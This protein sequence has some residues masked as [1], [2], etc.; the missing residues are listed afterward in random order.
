MA[1]LNYFATQS[2]RSHDPLF[3]D[4][5]SKV[6]TITSPHKA[7][8]HIRLYTFAVKTWGRSNYS[9]VKTHKDKQKLL[10]FF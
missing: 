7:H 4:P 10:L 8:N 6:Q 1:D 5:C 2:G 9:T 3:P